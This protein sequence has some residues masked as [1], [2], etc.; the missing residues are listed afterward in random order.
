[1]TTP[2]VGTE[3]V[4]ISCVRSD[5]DGT[6]QGVLLQRPP[7]LDFSS[8]AWDTSLTPP[9]ANVSQLEGEA[10]ACRGQMVGHQLQK[11]SDRPHLNT[12]QKH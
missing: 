5:G 11:N 10:L 3:T 8:A 4:R 1:M 12:K 7:S 6:G 2:V 9:T